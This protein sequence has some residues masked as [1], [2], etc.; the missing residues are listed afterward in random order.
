MGTYM[1]RLGAK[2]PNKCMGLALVIYK[3]D[4]LVLC[5]YKIPVWIFVLW[6][7]L[8]TKIIRHYVPITINGRVYVEFQHNKSTFCHSLKW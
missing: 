2:K 4:F 8:S 7:H 5:A 6:N 1:L 3:R